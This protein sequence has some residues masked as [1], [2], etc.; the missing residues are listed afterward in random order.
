MF[1]EVPE[2][3]DAEIETDKSEN[4]QSSN[5][6]KGQWITSQKY[7]WHIIELKR[8]LSCV[9]HCTYRFIIAYSHLQC[10]EQV[11]LLGFFQ[12]ILYPLP[13]GGGGYISFSLSICLSVH[14]SAV[15]VPLSVCPLSVDMLLSTHVLGNG[16]MEFFWNFVCWLL[17]IWRCAPGIIIFLQFTGL[18]SVFWT[19]H[20]LKQEILSI[21]YKEHWKCIDFELKLL[22]WLTIFRELCLM[23][24]WRGGGSNTLYMFNKVQQYY[25]HVWIFVSILELKLYIYY[26]YC[27]LPVQYLKI[28]K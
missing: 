24:V 8:C 7:C 28:L 6:P 18:F 11:E 20:I 14:P 4:A 10:S 23:C 13:H 21:N 16:C 19:C 25:V 12:N 22:F 3:W 5:E 9:I 15:S 26:M 2:N 17:T 1:V 27:D